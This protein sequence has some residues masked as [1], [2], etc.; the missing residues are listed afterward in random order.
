MAKKL[1]MSHPCLSLQIFDKRS[2]LYVH[3]STFN[4][5]IYVTYHNMRFVK[6]NEFAGKAIF[7]SHNHR[8]VQ[9]NVITDPDK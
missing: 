9:G 5:S 6:D 4:V 2:I 7:S 3:S 1:Y 8:D